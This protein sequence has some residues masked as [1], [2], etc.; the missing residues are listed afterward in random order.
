MIRGTQDD[1]VSS[2]TRLQRQA[3]RVKQQL[4][5]V[6][7]TLQQHFQ[8]IPRSSGRHLSVE[9]IELADI[10]SG[11]VSTFKFEMEKHCI[12]LLWK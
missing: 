12:P 1:L 3:T 11:R 6:L 7:D 8:N 10:G 5:G 2:Q 9:N 4:A